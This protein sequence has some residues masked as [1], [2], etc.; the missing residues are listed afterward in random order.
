MA[1]TKPGVYDMPAE[2]YLADPV[3]GGSLSSSGARKLLPPSCPAKYRWELDHPPAPRPEWDFGHAAHKLILGAGPDIVVIDAADW[4][5]KAAREDRDAA[6]AADQVPMLAADYEQVQAMEKALLEHPVAS[7]L[8]A[9]G[10]GRPEQSLFWVDEPTGIWRR[11]RLD[12]LRNPG[13]GR[14]ITPDY[15]TTRAADLD[16]IARSVHLFG[17]FQ[18]AA[19]YLDGVHALGLAEEGESAF[20]LVFQ[21][22]AAPYLITVVELDVM[23]LR[24]GRELNRR[25]IELYAQ[26]RQADR[27]PGY[28]D[29]IEL[30]PLPVWAENK[31]LE[32]IR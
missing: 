11:A 25:A 27:W 16:S 10:T 31:L 1:I 17:Y 22:K 14:L 21:E 28:S 15:K 8:F 24:L 7:K 32:E 9:P 13:P 4:K 3:P 23:A 6:Y 12:W 26:C 18:Q 2:T 5:T 20:V 19:W 30:I 29:G